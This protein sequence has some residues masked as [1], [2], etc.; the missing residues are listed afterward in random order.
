V[1]TNKKT[2]DLGIIKIIKNDPKTKVLLRKYF[3]AIL[4]GDFTYNPFKG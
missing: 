2:I 1:T 3:T 4:R